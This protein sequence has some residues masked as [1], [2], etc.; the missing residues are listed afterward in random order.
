MSLTQL[1][2]FKTPVRD[3]L[4]A[5][6]PKPRLVLSASLKVA[7]ASPNRALIGTAFDYLVRFH[8]QRTHA[9]AM[10]YP[11]VAERALER[12]SIFGD[13]GLLFETPARYVPSGEVR[14]CIRRY[15]KQ[16]QTTVKRFVEGEPLSDDLIRVTLRLAYCDLFY[17]SFR[18]DPLFG[19]AS[20]A[21]VDELRA[22]ISE[23]DWSQWHAKRCCLLN[24]SFGKGSEWIGGA[25]ADVLLDD[26][27]IDIKTTANLVL[28]TKDW[29]QILCYAALNE[30]FAIGGSR[31]RRIRRLGF[32]FARYGYFVTWPVAKLVVPSVFASFAVWLRDYVREIEVER[33]RLEA[34]VERRKRRRK[35]EEGRARGPKRAK[36]RNAVPKKANH[37]R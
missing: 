20:R 6:F 7:P 13:D 22:L 21:Q 30:H 9:F 16:A 1:I 10:S 35:R 34:G 11:W 33:Q 32:Y 25:D 3:R 19:R 8:L 18:Y 4:A 23:V 5:D 24:P 29:R 36:R 27:L 26:T 15:L 28:T 12:I 31:P 14:D 17:R 37:L 2:Q